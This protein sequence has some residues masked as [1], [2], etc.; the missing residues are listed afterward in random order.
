ML[1]SGFHAIE[2]S[3]KRQGAAGTLYFARHNPRI[4]RIIARARELPLAVVQVS[5]TELDRLCRGGP[6]RGLVLELEQG[7]AQ[8][9]GDLAQALRRLESDRALVLL[10]DG[11]TDPQ[12]LGAI[13]RSAD[14]F[15]VD[16]V[17]LPARRSGRET[18]TVLRTSAGASAHISLL[19]VPNLAR[20]IGL[21]K[22]EGFWVYGA[23][24][25]GERADLLSLQGRVAL[26]MGSEGQGLRRLVAESCDSLVRIP[27]SGKVDSLN[28]SVAA[29]ILLYEIRGQQGFPYSPFSE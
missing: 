27:A 11:I 21:C 5:P 12:N 25:Q 16:L 4:D 6:H 1:V 24:L 20:A 14:Q 10:L 19:V 17:L 18:E 3:L 22:K 8:P 15:A 26:V 7:P 2:E 28:V 9:R 23:H 13:L 29:G